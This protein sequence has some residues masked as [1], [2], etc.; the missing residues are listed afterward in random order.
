MIRPCCTAWDMN[1]AQYQ[2]RCTSRSVCHSSRSIITDCSDSCPAAL[3][4]LSELC[5]AHQLASALPRRTSMHLKC[6]RFMTL[7]QLT[8][9][10]SRMTCHV[11]RCLKRHLCQLHRNVISSA[12]ACFLLTYLITYYTV[13]GLGTTHEPTFERLGASTGH[14]GMPQCMHWWHPCLLLLL[15]SAASV[16]QTLLQ[17]PAGCESHEALPGVPPLTQRAVLLGVLMQH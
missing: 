2:T 5:T 6:R 14:G 1:I 9:P 13:H 10:S 15:S 8:S 7:S 17:L 3:P 12:T 4:V 16:G 11:A